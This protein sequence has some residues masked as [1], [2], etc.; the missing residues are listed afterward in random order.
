MDPQR[1]QVLLSILDLDL[2]QGAL[3]RLEDEYVDRRNKADPDGILKDYYTEQLDHIVLL[4][5][6][7]SRAM[8]VF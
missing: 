3:L 7:L 8:E 6:R 2:L 1:S 5:Q 4:K